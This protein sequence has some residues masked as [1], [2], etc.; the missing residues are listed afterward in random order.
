MKPGITGGEIA[1]VVAFDAA[2]NQILSALDGANVYPP[3]SFQ[4]YEAAS[5]GP[6]RFLREVLFCAQETFRIP[7]EVARQT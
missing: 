1:G 2:Q 3:H 4:I 5:D 6:L 7:G